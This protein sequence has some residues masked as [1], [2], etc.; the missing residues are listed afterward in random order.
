MDQGD[1]NIVR[2]IFQNT[3]N[4]LLA[5]ILYLVHKLSILKINFLYVF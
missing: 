2:I 3:K 1:L 5:P 4:Y